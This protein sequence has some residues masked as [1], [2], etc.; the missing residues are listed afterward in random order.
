M[1]PC[2]TAYTALQGRNDTA[3]CKKW[4]P[5]T[6]GY[7]TDVNLS[8]VCKFSYAAN[9]GYWFDLMD[10]NYQMGD[11]LN[12]FSIFVIVVYFVTSSD[13]GSLVVDFIAANGMEAHASQ[14]VFWA[15]TEGI[16]AIALLLS[17]GSDALK[18]LR[19]VSI[20]SGV[21]LTIFC[22]LISLS[23]NLIVKMDKGEIV[24]EQYF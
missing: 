2:P 6:A 10:Q 19:A 12:V 16:L 17:R 7:S 21:P 15:F 24:A 8:P 3:S 23:L 9:L 22:S 20:V 1:I 13:S 5:Y 18:G 11:V 14:R 4:Y